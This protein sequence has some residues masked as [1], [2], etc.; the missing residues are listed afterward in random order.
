MNHSEKSDRSH[1][2]SD[3]DVKDDEDPRLAKQRKL[4]SAPAQEGVTPRPQ[5]HPAPTAA[6]R[7]ID[8][9]Q[10]QA[11]YG[12]L[13]TPV[14]DE[15]HHTPRTSRSPPAPAESAPAAEY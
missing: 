7:D 5:S 13:P 9:T 3:K 8:D 12:H 15:H 6:Q 2:T 14:D 11:D 10:S 4:L 1:E